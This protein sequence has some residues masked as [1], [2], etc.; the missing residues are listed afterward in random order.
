M[1]LLLSY[2]LVLLEI[3]PLL[4]QVHGG[5]AEVVLDVGNELLL[6]ELIHDLHSTLILDD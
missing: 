5:V 2:I 6:Q 3:L 4:V 1:R